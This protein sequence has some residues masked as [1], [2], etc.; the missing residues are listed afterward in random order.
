MKTSSL[1]RLALALFL[2]AALP[3]FTASAAVTLT[4]PNLVEADVSNF[5]DSQTKSDAPTALPYLNTVTALADDDSSSTT[6]NLSNS[7]FIF[8]FNQIAS[9]SKVSGKGDL[10]FTVS[11]DTQYNLT[12]QF[13]ADDATFGLNLSATLLDTSNPE[14]PLYHSAQS[15]NYNSAKSLTLGGADGSSS[16]ELSGSPTGTLLA[17]KT[18]EFLVNAG[19]E[20]PTDPTGTGTVTLAF[21]PVTGPGGG[22]SS[23]PLPPAIWVGAIF[24]TGLLAWKR[25]TAQIG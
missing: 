16:N 19:L 12:G 6:A 21:A 15:G 4:G 23:A 25:R 7:A 3:A 20:A 8:S 17:G 5:L 1:A 10:F 11:T 14:S 24:A 22:G 9:F 18:Y 13:G 2:P